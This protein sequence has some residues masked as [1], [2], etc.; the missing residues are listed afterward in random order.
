M[1]K[2]KAGEP[3]NI[4]EQYDVVDVTGQFWWNTK[5]C[6]YY[7]LIMHHLRKVDICLIHFAET[8]K[9]Y[10]INAITNLLQGECV[11][12]ATTGKAVYYIRCVTVQ[13]PLKLSIRSRGNN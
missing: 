2:N 8:A 6:L 1:D 4:D 9:V 13:S 12:T 3:H 5:S 7:Y 11:V 10:L